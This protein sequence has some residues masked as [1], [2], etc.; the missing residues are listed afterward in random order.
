MKPEILLAQAN[1]S[2]AVA[3]HKFVLIPNKSSDKLYCFFEGKDTHYYSA[4]IQ[5]Y[6]MKEYEPIICGNKAQVLHTYSY[7]LKTKSYNKYSKAY[8]VDSDFDERLN[9]N[10]IYE[11][12]CYSIE[13]LYVNEYAIKQILKAEFFLT[14]GDKSFADA[15]KTF[16]DNLNKFNASVLLFNGWYYSLKKKKVKEMLKTTNVS[17]NDKLP[18]NLITFEINSISSNYD[19]DKINTIFPEALIVTEGEVLSCVECLSKEDLSHRL[20]GKYQIQFLKKILNHFIEDCNIHGSIF[21]SKTKFSLNEA[22]LMS[23]LSQYALTPDCL[24][25]YLKKF[26]QE[27][28]PLV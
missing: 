16:K 6:F 1:A 20:R 15:I 23:Q 10:D 25:E 8:F 11:T 14:S 19:L 17:L 27:I 28:P 18:K 21:K 3:V 12:P 2:T 5:N 4:R 7:F 13:N 26:N 22:N 9:N 24:I